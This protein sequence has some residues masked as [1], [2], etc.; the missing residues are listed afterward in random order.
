MPHSVVTDVKR[1]FIEASIHAMEEMP[2]QERHISMTL[3]G[4]SNKTYQ[5]FCEKIDELRKN[6]LMHE[7]TKANVDKIIALNIQ[8]FPV[9]N[10]NKSTENQ[11]E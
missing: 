1:T 9:S 4:I 7:E 2:K 3:K 8:M 6:I 10:I 5:L 11:G